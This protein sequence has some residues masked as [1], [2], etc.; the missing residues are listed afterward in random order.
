MGRNVL[1]KNEK[2]IK[3]KYTNIVIFL[4][5]WYDIRKCEKSTRKQNVI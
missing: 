3:M 4:I 1:Q 5:I 2:K